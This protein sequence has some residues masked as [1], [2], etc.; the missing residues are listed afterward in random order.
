MKVDAE[1]GTV[2]HL[3]RSLTVLLKIRSSRFTSFA[4]WLKTRA[5]KIVFDIA[6]PKLVKLSALC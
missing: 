5:L 3:W 2:L 6:T 4:A 1:R